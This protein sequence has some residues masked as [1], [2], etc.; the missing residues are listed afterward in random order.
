MLRTLVTILALTH[1]AH[2]NSCSGSGPVSVSG[3]CSEYNCFDGAHIMGWDI[4]CDTGFT[5]AQCAEKCCSQFNCEG[6]DYSATDHGMGAGRCCTSLMSRY[7]AG[8][9]FEQNGGTYRSCEKNSITCPTDS[10]T[11]CWID[12][13]TESHNGNDCFEEKCP[14][15][16]TKGGNWCKLQDSL[17]AEKVC[18]GD[19]CCEPNAGAIAGA[20][21]G[22]V[23][24]VTLLIVSSCYCGRCGCFAYRRNQF[25]APTVA[26]QQPQQP[27]VVYVQA[28]PANAVASV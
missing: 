6:F 22:A 4:T 9:A 25:I 2:A 14:P 19:D 23:I 12:V 24:G 5:E 28:P 11:E 1:G 17:Q 7:L 21:I 27:Q 3:S 18:C 15:L 16:H 10:V 20:V 26:M 8:G 13:L